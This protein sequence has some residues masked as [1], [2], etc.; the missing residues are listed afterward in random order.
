MTV[1]WLPTKVFLLI[2]LAVSFQGRL[3]LANSLHDQAIANARAGRYDSAITVLERL[4]RKEPENRGFR[5]DLIAVL[6][7]SERHSE[8]ISVSQ[9]LLLDGTVP[10]YVLTAVGKSALNTNQTNRALEAYG[11]LSSR[12]P[13]DVDASQGLASAMLAQATWLAN[14]SSVPLPLLSQNTSLSARQ[15]LNGQH[16]RDAQILLDQNF[17]TERYRLVDAALTENAELISQARNEGAT[18]VLQRLRSDRVVALRDRGFNVQAIEEFKAL[19]TNAI[20]TP[21]YAAAAAAEAYLNQRQ[22]QPAI[23]LFKRAIKA[24]PGNVGWS[25][26][27]MY[28]ELEAENLSNAQ[29]ISE[30]YVTAAGHSAAARRNHASFLRLVDRLDPSQALLNVLSDELPNDAGLWLEQGDLLA[31]RGLPRAAAARYAAV[32]TQEP[33]SIKARVGLADA[34]WAQGAVSEAA[35]HINSLN[36]EAP[37]HPAVQRLMRAWQRNARALLSSSFTIGFGQGFVAGN[38]DLTWESTLFSGMTANGTR[39][40]ANHH[41]AKAT[42]NAQSA[43]HQR[44]GAGLEWTQRDLQASVELGRDLHNAQDMVWAASAGWQV[45]DEFSLRVRHES[46]TNDFPLK[47]RQPDAESYLGAPTYLYADKTLVGVAYRWNE[48]RRV[49]FDMANYSFND[50]NDRTSLSASWFERLYSGYGRTLDLV[51]AA[52]TSSNTL[53]DAIYFNPKRD[54]AWSA[55]LTGDWLTWRHY[56]RSFNQ[57]LALTLGTYRQTSELSFG[58]VWFEQRYGSNTFQDLRYEHEW[59][60]GPDF[61]TRYGLGARRFPYDGVYELKNYVYAN[62]NWRF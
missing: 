39:F 4:V 17:T 49:A 44:V 55:T 35:R 15:E 11:L 6:S 30:T 62:V 10:D 53:R 42:F 25:M 48:S 45:N 19:D 33:G 16:I 1:S 9:N 2:I 40:F 38:D 24:E 13:L 29:R 59:Q 8:A 21:A 37:E 46:Q 34:L 54:V 56:E 23:D 32:L 50:G 3:A 27:L 51:A 60:W 58:P 22:P 7:W 41:K 61:S 43:R 5:Y 57:R 36:L 26:G 14:R 18:D 20:Q 47:A 12:R 52:Y 28:A 31:R